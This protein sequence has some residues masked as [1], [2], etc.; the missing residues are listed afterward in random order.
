MVSANQYSA[1]GTWNGKGVFWWTPFSKTE[2]ETAALSPPMYH[3]LFVLLLNRHPL[4]VQKPFCFQ[5]LQKWKA[6]CP[7]QPLRAYNK[8]ILPWLL[9]NMGSRLASLVLMWVTP[10]SLQEILHHDARNTAGYLKHAFLKYTSRSW[11]ALKS[12]SLMFRL[13][14]TRC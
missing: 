5:K 3:C 7:P 11:S 9:K 1:S 13:H 6:P 12:Y 8:G 4:I 2:A 14:F 10:H